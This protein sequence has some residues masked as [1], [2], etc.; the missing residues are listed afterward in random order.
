MIDTCAHPL[1]RERGGARARAT[2]RRAS[3]AAYVAATRGATA[4]PVGDVGQDDSGVRP[5][6]RLECAAVGLG[7]PFVSGFRAAFDR[8]RPPGLR[9]CRHAS[10]L[11]AR[12]QGRVPAMVRAK[13]LRTITGWP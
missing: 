2:G 3:R 12:G 5:V 6:L 11:E 8:G 7:I 13:P 9:R 10:G 1:P 4:V